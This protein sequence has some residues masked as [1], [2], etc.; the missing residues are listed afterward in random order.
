M[1]YFHIHGTKRHIGQ[2][3]ELILFSS[4]WEKVTKKGGI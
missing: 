2:K 1:I 4:G 3:E